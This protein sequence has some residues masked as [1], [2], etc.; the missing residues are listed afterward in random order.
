MSNGLGGEDPAQVARAAVAGQIAT[1]LIEADRQLPGRIDAAS[2]TVEADELSKVGVDDILD[3][4]G[5]IV[6]RAGGQVVVVPAER[7]PTSTGVAA[8]Y[9]Y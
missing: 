8:I 6:L 2:G 9:R 5:E 1:L 7:M 3:D 4:L